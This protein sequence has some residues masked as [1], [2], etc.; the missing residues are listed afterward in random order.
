MRFD[1]VFLMMIFFISG[2]IAGSS[3]TTTEFTVKGCTFDFEGTSVGVAA[4]SCSITGDAYGYFY[5]TEDFNGLL[6]TEEG[7]G[8]SMGE[9]DFV[10]GDSDCCPSGMLC[11]KTGDGTFKCVDRIDNC[12]NQNNKADCDAIGCLWF[13][14]TKECVDS[15]SDYGCNYYDKEED[16]V[17]DVWNLG[18]IG[19]GTELCGSEIECAGETYSVSED[20]CECKWNSTLPDG[21]RCKTNMI[22]TQRYYTPGTVP[23]VFE[24]STTYDLEECIDGFQNYSWIPSS[25]ILGGFDGGTTSIPVEC[26]E[27]F[28]CVDGSGIRSCGEPLIRVSGFS[29]F[30]LFMAV[31]LIG[32]FYFLKR[33]SKI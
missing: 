23:D 6:T 7:L 17:A 12:I 18:T 9:I 22:G 19:V 27:A 24:C 3:S 11:N 14:I 15:A 25:S 2:V 1:I 28:N 33:N 32:L 20:G 29:L 10:L 8:C 21:K 31:G 13:D 4:G 5:C 26:L 30:S 16:C